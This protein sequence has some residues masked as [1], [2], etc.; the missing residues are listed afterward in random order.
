VGLRD[1]LRRLRKEAESDAV[2]IRQ[3]DGTVKA[4]ETMEVHKQ[5]FLAKMDLFRKAWIDSEV[6]TAVRRATPESRAAFEERFGSI[7]MTGHV[8]ASVPQGGWAKAYALKE[9]GSVAETFHE[10]GSAK[11]ERIRREARR[12][13]APWT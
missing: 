13:A 3:R 9:D 10:G 5:L 6:L 2:L 1:R 12:G 8:V 11:A 7:A 4:F